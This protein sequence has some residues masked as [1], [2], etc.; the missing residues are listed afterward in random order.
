MGENN[1]TVQ[2]PLKAIIMYAFY[3]SQQK[4]WEDRKAPDSLKTLI[5]SET[6]PDALFTIT[7]KAGKLGFFLKRILVDLNGTIR[8]FHRSIIQNLPV[9]SGYTG[10]YAQLV[11][12]AANNGD[13]QKDTAQWVIDEYIAFSTTLTDQYTQN[14]NSGLDWI[15]N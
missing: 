14:Y 7:M 5:G 13:P 1:I 3:L 9:I 10:L 12:K 4:L 2:L 8:D 6:D 11:A 15:N